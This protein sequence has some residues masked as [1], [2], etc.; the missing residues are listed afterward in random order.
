[1]QVDHLVWYEADAGAGQRHFAGHMDATPAFGGVHPGGGTCNHLLSLGERTYVEILGRD[2]DQDQGDLDPELAG[3][4]G[5]GL[6]HWAMSGVDLVALRQRALAA[7]LNGSALVTGG[8]R[9]PN[10]N[11][12]GWQCFGL[13]DHAFGAQVPFFIDWLDSRHPA[14]D[15]PRGG[16]LSHVDVASPDAKGLGAI[17]AALGLG[18]TVR[19]AETPE[20]SVTLHSG[21][22]DH[23]LRMFDP[24]PR[25]FVI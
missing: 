3:L 9:L 13:N 5:H 17:Y 15:A 8:R 24:I 22:G 14:M 19:Q 2:P 1:M 18:I 16:T 11:W 21:R 10:G 20:L 6:Y 4:A 7:G 25:G 23:V 12:L